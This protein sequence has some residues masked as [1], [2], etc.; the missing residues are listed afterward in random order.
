MCTT[1]CYFILQKCMQIWHTRHTRPWV[2]FLELQRH[3]LLGYVNIVCLALMVFI[4]MCPRSMRGSLS[5]ILGRFEDYSIIYGRLSTGLGAFLWKR[6]QRKR[7][8][9]CRQY[10]IMC[11]YKSTDELGHDKLVWKMPHLKQIT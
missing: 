10:L 8:L 5:N 3:L 2:L 7:W 6:H 11:C 4:N 1:H 9:V